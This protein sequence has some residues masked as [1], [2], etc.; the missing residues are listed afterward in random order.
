MIRTLRVR[1]LAV[2][3]DLELALTSGLNV[4]TGETGAGKSLLVT[5][6]GLLRGQ[7]ASSDQ[8][9]AG[10]AAAELE[11]L[12]DDPPALARAR[13]LGLADPD[14]E[15]LVVVRS[16]SADGRGSVRVNGRLASVGL[17]RRLLRDSLE[18]TGQGEHQELVR[19]EVQAGLLDAFAG[20]QSAVEELRDLWERWRS[21]A[22][23]LEERRT[24]SAERARERDRLEHE[25]RA[26][27]SVA[28]EPG[29]REILEAERERL[30][31]VEELARAAGSGLDALDAPMAGEGDLGMRERLGGVGASLRE[32]GAID[33]QLEGAAE[34]L[35]RAALELDEATA[36]LAR[37]LADLEVDPDRLEVVEERLD[38][39]GRLSSR[40]GNEIAE[41]LAYRD[42][43]RERLSELTG[44]SA[45]SEALESTRD[46]LALELAEAAGSIAKRRREAAGE[47]E[48]GCAL[49]LRALDLAGA[50]LRIVF[51]PQPAL[52]PEGLEA[53]C[54]PTGTERA[55]FALSANPGEDARKLRGAASGGELS[56]LLLALRNALRGA[57]VGRTLLFDEV[58]AGIGGRTARRVGE[59]LCALSE[60]HQVVC[61][62]HLPQ[63]AALGQAHWVVHKQLRAG[64]TH[65]RLERVEG[66]ARV[67]EIARMS[68]RGRVTPAGLAHARELLR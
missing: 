46:R 37:Y 4:V 22:R 28:P 56:R 10:A 11:A 13:D 7:R 17:L 26:I 65:V 24:S 21:A 29:E 62:T 55:R 39:L 42:R 15:E 64:R 40:Y 23:E 32:A 2:I 27:D 53:P 20:L 60:R 12:L 41:I 5:A 48:A 59:R 49:E 6:F 30:R 33:P 57:E 68:A 51:D 36:V 47:L 35:S 45:R 44:G 43:A 3:E 50:Q 54:A 19:P 61:V 14:D 1:K 58:D 16:V 34:A 67:S 9:R 52:T 18:I 25:I 31:H 66:D 8:V 38:S 63:I